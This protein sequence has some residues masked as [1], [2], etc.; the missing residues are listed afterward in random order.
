MIRL[1]SYVV[2]TLHIKVR[3]G[4][5]KVTKALVLGLL[6]KRPRIQT[7]EASNIK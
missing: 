3:V 4:L 7:K 5:S 2:P 6:T 1:L